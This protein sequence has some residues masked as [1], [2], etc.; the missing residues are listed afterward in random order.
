MFMSEIRDW[1]HFATLFKK[2]E[3]MEVTTKTLTGPGMNTSMGLV[4]RI[5]GFGLEMTRSIA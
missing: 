1:L 3:F 5:R 2:E 4:T